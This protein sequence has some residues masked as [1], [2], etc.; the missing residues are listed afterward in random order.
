VNSL[1]ISYQREAGVEMVP[2]VRNALQER[3]AALFIQQRDRSIHGFLFVPMDVLERS[4]DPA[5]SI[6]EVDF[7]SM[8][9]HERRDK[10]DS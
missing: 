10:V 8:P 9:V 1:F 3:G 2:F 6:E 7:N 5:S 4:G